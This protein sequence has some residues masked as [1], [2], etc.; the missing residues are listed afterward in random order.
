[1]DLKTCQQELDYIKW[2]DSILMGKDMCG[3]YEYC[4]YCDKKRTYPCARAK[5][6]F[7]KGIRIAIIRIR[8]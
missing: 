1:M 5:K 3:T 4:K 7:D 2:T 8:K 6:R